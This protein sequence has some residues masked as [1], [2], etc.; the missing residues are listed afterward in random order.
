MAAGLGAPGYFSRDRSPGY[1]CD[2]MKEKE[3]EEW[4]QGAGRQTDWKCSLERLLLFQVEA[5]EK[6][7]LELRLE[8]APLLSSS[9]I[10][11]FLLFPRHNVHFH[12]CERLGHFIIYSKP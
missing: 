2:Q 10:T 6:L 4:R 1:G 8:Q 11:H 3:L 9:L 7:Y 12:V 5:I